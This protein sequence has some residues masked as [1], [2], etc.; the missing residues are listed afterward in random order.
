MFANNNL[1]VMSLG[2]PDVCIVGIIP[3]PEANIDFSI[4]NI[5]TVFNVL[6]GGGLVENLITISTLSTADVGVGVV[7]GM[8]MGPK[9][10]ILGSF[11]LL[12]GAIFVSRLTSINGQNGLLP[13]T[14]GICLLP[15]Q[16]RVLVLS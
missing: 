14:V 11:K 1:G 4:T 12:V 5:P 7:S 10:S 3:V 9:R 6:Y 16:F 8:C 2:F 15:T 13:N